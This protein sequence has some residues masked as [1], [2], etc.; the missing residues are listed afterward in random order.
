[1]KQHAQHWVGRAGLDVFG[2]LPYVTLITSV[3]EKKYLSSEAQETGRSLRAEQRANLSHKSTADWSLFDS[4][5]GQKERQG[6]GDL[7]DFVV[8]LKD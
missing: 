7:V 5:V 4:T 6:R 3:L 2:E 8:T 1:M